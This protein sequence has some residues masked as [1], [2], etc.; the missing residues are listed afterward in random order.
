MFDL[1]FEGSK[2]ASDKDWRKDMT[3][4]L[5]RT[6]MVARALLDSKRSQYWR[7]SLSGHKGIHLYLDFPALD[8]HEGSATQFRNG[9][10]KYTNELLETIQ[11]ETGLNSLDEYVDVMS[12]KDFAR[13]TRL[14]NTIHDTATRRFGETRFCVP[15][16]IEELAEITV[17]D[18]VRLTQ[19]PRPLPD[20]CERIESQHVHDVLVQDIRMAT[21]D[22]FGSGSTSATYNGQKVERYEKAENG[23]VD[24]DT[25]K[26]TLR[27]CCWDFRNRD[28]RF[29]HGQQSHIMELNCMAEM[30][31]KQTPIEVMVEF[32]AVDEN[33]SEGYTREKINDVI[34]YS[35]QPFT[36]KKLRSAASVFF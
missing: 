5:V 24:L 14:P 17:D 16:T 6:R 36:L 34:S 4:L 26:I 27:D 2:N 28:D 25:L 33:F 35:Y 10:G 30:I 20:G 11:S 8:R 29:A 15:V 12:G 9:V 18:Y 19:S 7:A 22:S 32:F 3:A 13:L 31:A 23:D 21:H 1:D